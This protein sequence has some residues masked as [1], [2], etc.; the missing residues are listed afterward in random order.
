MYVTLT[1]V[2]LRMHAALRDAAADDDGVWKGWSKWS[3]SGQI[4]VWGSEVTGHK[5]ISLP[6]WTRVW[7]CI[8]KSQSASGHI[9]IPCLVW[10]TIQN[11]E[12]FS[13]HR[14]KQKNSNNSHFRH[15][16]KK[17]NHLLYYCSGYEVHLSAS[18]LCKDFWMFSLHHSHNFIVWYFVKV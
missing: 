13:Y 8:P 17:Q 10:W 4:N 6:V 12:V 1:W 2:R 3:F 14:G 7:T 11:A 15:W 18:L 5:C 9:L 16:L